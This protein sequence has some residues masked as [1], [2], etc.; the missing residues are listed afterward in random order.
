[1]AKFIK[2]Q[3]AL[4]FF[5][6]MYSGK[7]GY[8]KAKNELVRKFGPV[9]AESAE[10]DFTK[11]SEYYVPE[12]GRKQKKRY[13]VFERLFD[14]P[15]LADA[16]LF[17]QKLE[18]R[19]SKRGKRFV[20]IDPGYM[21]KDAIVLASLKERGHKIYLGRGVFADL[22]AIFGRNELRAFEYTF[23]DL[24]ANS[25]FFLSVR[26]DLLSVTKKI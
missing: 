7:Q 16:R 20:N 9:R 6:L 17:T 10:F 8:E 19:L 23:E 12:M 1:M 5:A 4:L 21:T 13:V 15:G 14:R 2:P 25:A 24:K 11:F 18:Q 3:K 22:Q 26:R